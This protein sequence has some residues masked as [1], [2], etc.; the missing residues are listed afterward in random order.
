MHEKIK[1]AVVLPIPE[2]T[3]DKYLCAYIVGKDIDSKELKRDMSQSLPGYMIPT[4]FMMLDRMPLTPG[5]KIDKTALPDPQY[6]AGREEYVAPRDEIEK[7]LLEIWCEVLGI[8]PLKVSRS[9]GIDDNFFDLGGH[10]LKATALV[11]TLHEK[12][13]IKIP[14]VEIFKTPTIRGIAAVISAADWVKNQKTGDIMN[15]EQEIEELVI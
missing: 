12:L 3:G 7:K 1:E 8:D 5:G 2:T 10:S 15:Q 14:L 9:I 13:N 6:E 4:N 11:S